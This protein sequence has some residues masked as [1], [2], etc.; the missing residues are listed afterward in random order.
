MIGSKFIVNIKQLCSYIMYLDHWIVEE[1]LTSEI[2]I[3]WISVFKYSNVFE[4]S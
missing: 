1:P 4:N 2:K 3:L